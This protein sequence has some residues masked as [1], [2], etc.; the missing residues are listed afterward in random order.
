MVAT[1][2]ELEKW[3]VVGGSGQLG[4]AMQTELAKSG[5]EFLA[6]D[7]SQ[8]DVTDEEAVRS[9]IHEYRP[10][11]VLN[12]TGWTN[13]DDAENFEEAATLLNAAAPGYLAQACSQINSRFVH[14][15]TDYVFLGDVQSPWREDSPLSPVSAYGRSKAKGETLV[16][17]LYGD[18]S[19]IVRT[20][21]LYSP[22]GRNFVKTMARIALKEIGPVS[23]VNDQRGQPTSALD[24]ALQIRQMISRGSDPGTYHGTNNGEATWFEFAR[25]IF[26]KCGA[27]SERVVPVDSDHA[28]RP[29]KRPAYSVLS[30]QN[31]IDQGMDPMR[32]WREALGEMLP[33]II[34]AENLGE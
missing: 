23:V 28:P 25:H 10:S 18:G 1:V 6:L 22:W 2:K 5:T 34:S 9:A 8:L 19:Y 26:K 21:W 15:S 30:H 7:R 33:L 29:A 24:L 16:R 27:D 31:W 14:I 20:G 12:A 3:L 13:V 11:T 32:D 4:R 17:E